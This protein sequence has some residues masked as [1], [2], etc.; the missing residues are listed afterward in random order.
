[1][2]DPLGK[3]VIALWCVWAAVWVAFMLDVLIWTFRK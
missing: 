3:L 2:K 1:M